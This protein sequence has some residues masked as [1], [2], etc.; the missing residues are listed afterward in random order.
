MISEMDLF[1]ILHMMDAG[2]AP[3]ELR[4]RQVLD[5]IHGSSRAA[6]RRMIPVGEPP[7]IA[8]ARYPAAL[9]SYFP[10]PN[11]YA[12]LGILA[13]AMLQYPVA[14]ITIGRL[15]V[16]AQR[17]RRMF[18][19]TEASTSTLTK[20][21]TIPP[22][23]ECLINTRKS[24]DTYIRGALVGES[25]VRGKMIVGHP[26]ARTADQIFEVKLTGELKKNWS[27]FLCQVFAYA[28]LDTSVKHVYLVLPLHSTVVEFDVSGWADRDKYRKKMEEHAA[29]LAAPA[30]APAASTDP[31]TVLKGQEI[32]ANYNIGTHM[33][34][35]PTLL[36]TVQECP[37]GTPSQIFVGPPQNSRLTVKDD[38]LAAAAAW[39]TT[40]NLPIY[41]HA[42]YIINLAE[43][44]LPDDWAVRLLKKNLEVGAALGCRGVVVHVGKSKGADGEIAKAAMRAN[45][46]RALESATADCPLLL[47][48]PAGQGTEML[49]GQAEFIEFVTSFDSPR[50][51]ICLDTCH[52]FACG[53][54]PVEFVDACLATPD[55]LRLVHFNDS[56]DVCGACKDRHAFVGTGKIGADVLETV[57]S[58]CSSHNVPMVV[59]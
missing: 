12:C 45:I 7:E 47:E 42:P 15:C 53:H 1:A 28:A 33:P 41:I 50:L 9:L 46:S 51:R 16:E 34:K 58:R 3:S 25:E 59:E 13:E 10:K 23:L 8:V 4:V 11:Q 39:I 43:T 44:S 22:F 14:E 38:D 56:M 17:V 24:M 55:L 21:K 18:D 29:K 32:V 20:S 6:L 27:Y 40:H 5:G 2:A 30:T 48:T 37:T 49:R 54:K 35:H 26:D 36:Q 52:V 57:A 19:T 31:T